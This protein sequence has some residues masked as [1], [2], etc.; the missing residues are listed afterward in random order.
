MTKDKSSDSEEKEY[1]IKSKHNRH[2]IERDENGKPYNIGRWSDEEH[3][4]FMEGIEI[5]GK[6]W[7]QVQ[8]HVGTRSSA[9][10]RSHAQKVL[11]KNYYSKSLSAEYP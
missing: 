4:K 1:K 5:Y 11:A 10:S 3:R 9:Q 6:D 7:K 2:K 8:Q